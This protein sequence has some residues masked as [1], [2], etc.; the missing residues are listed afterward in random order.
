MH[1]GPSEAD[2]K[3]K[4]VQAA[5]EEQEEPKTLLGQAAKSRR[6]ALEKV[7]Q[8]KKVGARQACMNCLYE[9][10]EPMLST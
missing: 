2:K 7:K 4:L 8:V 6:D 1:A 5:A 10:G 9:S 3:L